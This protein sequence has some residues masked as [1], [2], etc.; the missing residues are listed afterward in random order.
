LE[1]VELAK[2]YKTPE[3]KMKNLTTSRKMLEALQ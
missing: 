1:G 2:K 3:Q